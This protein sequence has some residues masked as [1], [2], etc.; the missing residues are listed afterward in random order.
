[1]STPELAAKRPVSK[2]ILT[3][4]AGVVVILLGCA[5]AVLGVKAVDGLSSDISM[6]KQEI[7][8]LKAQTQES[9]PDDWRVPLDEV[10]KQVAA[11]RQSI[12]T[13]NVDFTRLG[14]SD[15]TLTSQVAS[16]QQ[17]IDVLDTGTR[18]VLARL[19]ALEQG[20]KTRAAEKS[21]DA[22]QRKDTPKPQVR[23]SAISVHAPFV[24]TGIERRGDRTFAAVTPR[25]ARNLDAVRLVAAGEAIGGWQFESAS[26]SQA[27]F[28]VAGKIHRIPVQ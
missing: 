10:K 9:R 27:V 28:R 24:V 20:L 2:K 6:M 21:L 7:V 16:Q 22:V 11:L 15:A 12:D 5:V 19:A 14:K 13:L 25:G 18:D 23:R 17:A 26:G 3:L 8:T 1:M 4:T